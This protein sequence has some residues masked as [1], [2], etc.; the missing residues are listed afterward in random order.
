ML[1][2][3]GTYTDL[4][5]KLKQVGCRDI[6]RFPIPDGFK[7]ETVAGLGLR[8]NIK[9]YPKS[10]TLMVQTNG[11]RGNQLVKASRLERDRIARELQ[12]RSLR[13]VKMKVR[14]KCSLIDHD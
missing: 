1:R 7:F 6:K 13:G 11:Q 9:W 14:Q 4:I 8:I 10:G 3:K 2:H 12:K 5:S